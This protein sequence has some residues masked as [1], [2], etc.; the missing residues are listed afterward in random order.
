MTEISAYYSTYSP[1]SPQNIGLLSLSLSLP[2]SPHTCPLSR[3]LR[4][5]LCLPPPSRARPPSAVVARDLSLSLSLSL[6]LPS[7]LASLPPQATLVNFWGPRIPSKTLG[8]DESEHTVEFTGG[9][10]NLITTIKQWDRKLAE[11]K[12]NG[13]MIAPLFCELS[14]QY[15]SLMFLVVDVDELIFCM[16]HDFR[17]SWDIKATL[18]FFFLRDGQQ[19]DKLVGAN[20]VELQKKI[21]AI[22]DSAP[23]KK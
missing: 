6:S 21:V 15:T 19:V 13:K 12:T 18:T 3:I 8:D 11:A 10:V 17:T 22:V 16:V 5:E 7:S 20:K 4:H 2:S 14:E 1:S 23:C 9:K